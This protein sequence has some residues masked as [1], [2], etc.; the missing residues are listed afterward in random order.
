MTVM[1]V[2]RKLGRW[3][4]YAQDRGFYNSKILLL[5]P[6]VF[7]TKANGTR[8]VDLQKETIKAFLALES[9]TMATPL[10]ERYKITPS[11]QVIFL[12]FFLK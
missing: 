7:S 1:H 11:Q 4:S 10:K 6:Y 12:Y 2:L 3:D 9:F 8:S 5:G